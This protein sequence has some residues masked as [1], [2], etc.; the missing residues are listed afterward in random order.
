MRVRI[1]GE[2]ERDEGEGDG[3]VDWDQ[4]FCVSCYGQLQPQDKFVLDIHDEVLI[5]K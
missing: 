1:R 3:A 2:G 4:R 5:M